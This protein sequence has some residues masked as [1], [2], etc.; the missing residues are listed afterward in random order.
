MI[1]KSINFIQKSNLVYIG[2]SLLIL[3]P[4][5]IPGYT[6]TFDMPWGPIMPTSSPS[7][8]TYL[9]SLLINFLGQIIPSWLIQKLILFSIFFLSGLGAHKL[10]QLKTNTFAYFAG[11]LY[12]FNP[13][14]YTRL[15]AG[16]WLVLLGYAFLPWA[17]RSIYIFIQNPSWKNSL[18]VIFWS[19]LICFTSIHTIGI[20]FVIGSLLIITRNRNPVSGNQT[21][22]LKKLIIIVLSLFIL[23]SYW[24]IP[25]LQGTSSI[26][27]NVSSFR[28]SELE[29]F[30]TSGTVLNSPVISATLLTGF[31]A[32]HQGRYILP[33]NLPIWWIGVFIIAALVIYGTYKIIKEKDKLGITL[34]ITGIIS[35][36][37]ALGISTPPTALITKFLDQT[38]PFYS[39]YREPHK[40]LML[41]ALFYSYASAVGAYFFK[42]KIK[43]SQLKIGLILIPI[44]FAPTLLF[45]AV[46]QLKSSDY[47]SGWYEANDKFNQ[48]SNIVVFPWHQYLPI[49]FTGRVVA[50]PARYFFKG[51]IFTSGDPELKGVPSRDSNEISRYIREEVIPHANDLE[52]INEKFKEKNINYV[53]L[54]KESDW[55]RYEWLQRSNLE[56]VLENENLILYKI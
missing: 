21:K 35:L 10:S 39:G 44:L 34:L 38:I 33:S 36:I 17:I 18:K 49:S 41:L 20:L 51:N 11:M 52:D 29:A 7:S 28:N 4:I 48:D 45:G 19:S 5:L 27:Q 2:I 3:L 50:N 12:I 37:L 47:P 14:V 43:N 25:T 16:Q 9:I 6:Q 24:L 1:K 30:S 46:G 53:I 55:N 8:N 40:W 42:L 31:W 32:D 23:N 26:S 56:K 22:Y 54:L 13:F 15:M